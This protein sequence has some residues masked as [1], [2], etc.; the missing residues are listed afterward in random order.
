[1]TECPM[2]HHVWNKETET[3]LKVR[4]EVIQELIELLK[5]EGEKNE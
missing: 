4:K 3:Y 1:M 5:K 2:C